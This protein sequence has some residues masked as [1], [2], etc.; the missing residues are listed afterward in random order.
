MRFLSNYR[1]LIIITVILQTSC[2]IL[3]SD[4]DEWPE[5]KGS[6]TAIVV[7]YN[8]HIKVKNEVDVEIVFNEFILYLKAN[9]QEINGYGN[10][11]R[12]DDAEIHGLYKGV[13]YWKIFSSWFS[14]EDQ[15]WRSKSFFDVSESGEVV[16]LLRG[17]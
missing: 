5:I 17:I 14:E 12:F 3:E 1:T 6:I 8:S 11:W 10:N 16:R 4:T 2:G 13:K 15:I 7:G 9:N